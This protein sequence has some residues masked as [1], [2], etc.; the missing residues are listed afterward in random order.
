MYKRVDIPE[1]RGQ[2]YGVSDLSLEVEAAAKEGKAIFVPGTKRPA[3]HNEGGYLRSHGWTAHIHKG[4]MN[5][6]T[7]FY[8]WA[9]RD[10]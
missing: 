7:G 3:V 2:G 5:G 1:H 9:V 6:E 4:E 10:G 8:V